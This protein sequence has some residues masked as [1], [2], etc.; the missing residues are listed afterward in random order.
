MKFKVRRIIDLAELVVNPEN[1]RFDPVETQSDA[2]DLMLEERGNE[3]FNLAKHIIENGLDEAKNLR[4]TEIKKDLY[5]ILEGNRRITA[6]KCL[7][8]PSLIKNESLRNKFINLSKESEKDEK[9]IPTKINCFVYND[10]TDASK[11]VKLDH[12]GKN[13]G[14]GLVEWG[15]AEKN[16]F[17][18]RFEGKLSPAMQA[19]KLYEGITK[20]KIDDPNK[21][22]LT[23]IDRILSNPES[24]SYIGLGMIG[25]EIYPTTSLK[26]VG[27]RLDKL[28]NKMILEKI[29][30][31]EFYNTELTIKF[32]KNLYGEKPIPSKKTIKMPSKKEAEE[33][34]KPKRRLPKSNDRNVLIPNTCDLEILESKINNIYHELLDIPLDQYP[35]AVGVL[36]RVF[37]ETSLDCYIE[38]YGISVKSDI[39]LAGKITK[40]VGDLENRKVANPNQ[41]KNI[42]NVAS[43]RD[44]ILSI[45]NFHEYVHSSKVQPTPTDLII[46]WEGLQEFFEIM[47]EEISKKLNKK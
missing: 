26:E 29:P 2:I 40:V 7:H 14:V 38:K 16:R 22:K 35:N 21:L 19:V 28:F 13:E 6:L 4:V 8:N 43:K 33:K 47:W 9:I 1:Y 41:L 17:A 44:S 36:F 18:E 42:N 25:G 23:T 15:T 5:K 30:V 10:E 32:I 31:K 12:T 20:S 27:E 45:E 24:R 37:L 34:K 11:W 46:K 3:I 39:K